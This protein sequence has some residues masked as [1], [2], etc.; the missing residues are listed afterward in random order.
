ME[1]PREVEVENNNNNPSSSA[2]ALIGGGVRQ[3]W[4]TIDGPLGL[5][6]SDSL[7][8]ARNFFI[9]GFFL[10]PLL[11]GVNC[12]LF[13]PV[14]RRSTSFPHLRPYIVRSAIA[15]SVFTAILGS[16]AITFIVGGE[17]LFGHTWDEL[18][19]YN[20]ADKYGLTGWI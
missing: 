2:S 15:F 7:W 14:L 20:V 4:P 3:Q 17:R 16:W 11:W 8:Y 12:Y 1:R 6:E 5:S 9:F 19:M 10:L 18:V 13:W